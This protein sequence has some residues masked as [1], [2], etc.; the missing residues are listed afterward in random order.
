MTLEN[1]LKILIYL[2]KNMIEKMNELKRKT[3]NMYMIQLNYQTLK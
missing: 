3:K 1:K 2:Y